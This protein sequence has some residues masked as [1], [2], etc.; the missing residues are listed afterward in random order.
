MFTEA[1]IAQKEDRDD[2]LELWKDLMKME[3]AVGKED[4]D[5]DETIKAWA[6]RLDKQIEEKKAIIVKGDDKT[7]GFACFIG[8]TGDEVKKQQAP[9]GNARKITIP[10]GIA[11][12][13]DVYVAPRARLTD[14]SMK[15]SNTLIEV[16]KKAGFSAVWTNTHADNKPMQA[17]LK[18]LGFSIL[19]NFTLK[20]RE[21]HLYY[22]KDL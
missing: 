22:K 2:I 4:I 15:L 5:I 19:E 17:F 7:V 11:Y 21:D 10:A 14:A 20:R 13:T 16:A 1:S 6:W 9:S 18:R 3:I 8:K 12:I